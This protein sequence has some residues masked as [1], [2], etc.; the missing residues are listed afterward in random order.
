MQPKAAAHK[1]PPNAPK[2]AD[3]NPCRRPLCTTRPSTPTLHRAATESSQAAARSA[4]TKPSPPGR[5][6]CRPHARNQAALTTDRS[7]RSGTR[8]QTARGPASSPNVHEEDDRRCPA[9]G[10]QSPSDPSSS[11]RT[12]TPCSTAPRRADHAAVQTATPYPDGRCPSS[13]HARRRRLPG[14]AA[15]RCRALPRRRDQRPPPPF[16]DEARRHRGKGRR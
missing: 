14:A 5:L 11:H 3:L 15:A 12:S 4:A 2:L 8:E 16:E 7:R 6:N 9:R 1:P 10:P 13:H